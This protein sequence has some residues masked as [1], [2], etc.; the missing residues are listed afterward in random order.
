[1]LSAKDD[2]TERRQARNSVVTRSQAQSICTPYCLVLLAL[3]GVIA[4]NAFFSAYLQVRHLP[5][6][7]VTLPVMV[8]AIYCGFR[9]ALTATLLSLVAA[10]YIAVFRWGGQLD[11]YQKLQVVMFLIVGLTIS[12]LGER[13]KKTQ[14]AL[15]ALALATAKRKDDFLAM[16]GHELRNPLAG[17]SSAAKLMSHSA[18]DPRGVSEAALIIHR[19]VVHMSV[20]I[21]DLLDVSRVTRGQVE[22]EKTPV[23]LIGVVNAAVE[24][25][26]ELV[27][28]RQ[29]R[30]VLNLP[31]EPVRV[32]G[33]ST[34]L[35]QV[36][37]NLLV[38]AARY[39]P[40]KGVLA[41]TLQVTPSQAE[42]S[43]QDNGVGITPEFAAHVFDLFV[44]AK[45]STDGVLGGLGL[46]L[47]LVKSMVEAHGGQV[48]VHSAGLGHGCTFS[49][50]LPLLAPVQENMRPIVLPLA[51]PQ[52]VGAAK[53][54]DILLV[55][56][57][58]DAVQPLAMLL[59]FEGHRVVVAYNGHEALQQAAQKRFDV[60]LLD[61]GLPDTDGYTLA[62]Q[63]KAMPQQ[64]GARLVALTGYGT[65]QDIARAHAAGF[66]QHFV[67][68]IDCDQLLEELQQVAPRISPATKTANH[69][70]KILNRRP[71]HRLGPDLDTAAV[72]PL[73]G[74]GDGQR[75]DG[76]TAFTG[77]G[78]GAQNRQQRNRSV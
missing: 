30:L 16:L 59:E 14:S 47:S 5:L 63:I 4:A 12:W 44:Q 39:T 21:N 54:L 23:D 73:P 40:P 69:A 45:R 6:V 22:I 61:I 17:I 48:S 72:Q 15:A 68:P 70:P 38:N 2:K 29:H 53:S 67:K 8:G 3:A 41:V 1:M 76:G 24:Q 31:T 20:L 55:D 43:V 51:P 78:G 77:R 71:L 35:V 28:H 66:D 62:R 11:D 52:L 7:G 74:T 26:S 42:L 57:N 32:L 50:A 10:C 33:D 56:D 34:R 19:Q 60:A 36:V 64:S 65:A 75:A 37:T 46:G 25:V 13:H 9:P 58:R 18:M 49:V 27:E